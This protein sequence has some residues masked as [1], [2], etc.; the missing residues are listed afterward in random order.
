MLEFVRKQA[1][2]IFRWLCW[3]RFGK[4]PQVLISEYE[5]GERKATKQMNKLRL[6]FDMWRIGEIN[7]NKLKFKIDLDHFTLMNG[8]FDLGLGKLTSEELADCF[9]ELCPCGRPHFPENLAKL[10]SR[11]IREFPPISP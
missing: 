1:E 6:E 5:S 2:F 7:P 9:D 4:T 10:R 3:F 8:G 11:I